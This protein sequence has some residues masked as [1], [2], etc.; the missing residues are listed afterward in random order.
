MIPVDDAYEA[1]YASVILAGT[2]IAG[3]GLFIAAWYLSTLRRNLRMN[4][5]RLASEAQRA[6]LVVKNAEE[7]AEA[8]REL[9]DFLGNFFL[10][11]TLS[12]V[13]CQLFR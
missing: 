7:A 8:E 5:L 11:S 1:N 10:A 2:L 6:A 3:G 13:V 12:V 4:E 9:N